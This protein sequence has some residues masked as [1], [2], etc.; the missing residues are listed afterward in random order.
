MY[1]IDGPLLEETSDKVE[2]PLTVKTQSVIGRNI[3]RSGTSPNTQVAEG[4]GMMWEL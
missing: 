1:S 3:G 4:R 2:H